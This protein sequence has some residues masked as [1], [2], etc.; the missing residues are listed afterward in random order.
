[1]KTTM[2][3]RYLYI[4]YGNYITLVCIY[5]LCYYPLFDLLFCTFAPHSDM[6]IINHFYCVILFR[7][8]TVISIYNFICIM[9]L[10][11]LLYLVVSKVL[12]RPIVVKYYYVNIHLLIYKPLV[13]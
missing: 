2:S 5:I 3:I 10:C 1:M 6:S 9:T 11:Y 12:L 7:F 8:L 4:K 13:I